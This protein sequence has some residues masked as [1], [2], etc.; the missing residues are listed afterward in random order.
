[1]GLLGPTGDCILAVLSP[2]L[3]S[4]QSLA[5]GLPSSSKAAKQC[6]VSVAAVPPLSQISLC[7]C[8]V[9]TLGIE[10]RAHQDNPSSGFLI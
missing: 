10:Y 7:L 8:I 1:M 9:R 5:W 2:K 4:S 3:H 6:L